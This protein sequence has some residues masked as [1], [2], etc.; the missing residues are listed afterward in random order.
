[1][2]KIT[3]TIGERVAVIEDNKIINGTIVNIFSEINNPIVVVKTEDGSC[4]KTPIEKVAK[5]SEE[6]SEEK[7]E[8]P[9]QGVKQKTE[10]TITPKEFKE[11]SMKIVSDEMK[12]LGSDGLM[13]GIAFT[14]LTAKL[15]K[16]LFVGEADN[17]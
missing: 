14:I 7:S 9:I 15:H 12:K 1:M 3:L 5:L 4:I 13:L 2:R 10:I 6:R 11:I 16:A 17:D 8:D